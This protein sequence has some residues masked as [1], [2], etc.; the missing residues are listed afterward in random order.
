MGFNRK[1]IE[2]RLE[3][4]AIT[5]VNMLLVAFHRSEAGRTGEKINTDDMVLTFEDHFDGDKLNKDV[6]RAHNFF[7]VRKGG[8]WSGSQLRLENSNLVITTQYREDGEFGPGWYTS[9][10]E[11]ED[12]FEQTYG[13][14]KSVV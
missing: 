14:R 6:W 8:Y 10:I 4:A 7:G 13:D 3:N 11:T 2:A 9:G 12:K 5:F 1:L